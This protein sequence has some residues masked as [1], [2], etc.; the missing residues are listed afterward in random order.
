MLVKTCISCRQSLPIDQYRKRSDSVTGRTSKCVGC[1]R[2]QFRTANY[3]A[4]NA[5]RQRKARQTAK[6]RAQSLASSRKSKA[7]SYPAY[8]A[9]VAADPVLALTRRIRALV[10]ITLKNKGY[11]KTSRTHQILGCTF[12]ELK[13][14][15]E[16][17]FSAGMSW[18]NF[19]EWHIDHVIPISL[20]KTEADVVRLNHYTNLQPLW[21][22]DNLLKSN[23][24]P[25][26]LAF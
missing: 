2:A 17:K 10:R 15:L 7:G 19:S 11:S 25:Y 13:A 1:I 24:V 5:D 3:R 21:A 6:G 18:A 14:H 22:K 23:K 20:A 9:K 16:S 4:K 26:A 12:E 8:K